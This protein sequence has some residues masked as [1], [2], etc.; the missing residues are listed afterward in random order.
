MILFIALRCAIVMMLLQPRLLSNCPNCPPQSASCVVLMVESLP[1]DSCILRTH[2]G[3]KSWK[4]P[5]LRSREL[6][7]STQDAPCRE[8]TGEESSLHALE[9][10]G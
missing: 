10:F 4:E 9:G 1:K 3:A 2:L 5:P 6:P 8:C 7:C